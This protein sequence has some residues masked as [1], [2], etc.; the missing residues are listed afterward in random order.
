MKLTPDE[1]QKI[2]NLTIDLLRENYGSIDNLKPPIRLDRLFSKYGLTL[3]VAEME[4]EGIAGVYD[5]D[6]KTIVVNEDDS[7]HRQVFTI[8][9]ELG[10][11]FLHK[12]LKWDIFYRADQFD[13]VDDMK[14]SELE[15]N[16]FAICLLMPKIVV[17]NYAWGLGR[18]V[19]RIAEAFE[20]SNRAALYRMQHL[21][22]IKD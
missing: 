18:N 1:L 14:K 2:D 8:A 22:L 12:E 11:F 6:K 13:H 21:G 9:H 4:E 15:A 20:V 7:Y 10:H 5:R 16:W 3:K 19:T 17:E